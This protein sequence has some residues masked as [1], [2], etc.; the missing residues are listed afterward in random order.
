MA[1]APA[2]VQVQVE[3]PIGDVRI[4]P[5]SRDFQAAGGGSSLELTAPESGAVWI[6]TTGREPL[7][8]LVDPP[9]HDVPQAGDNVTIF[10]PGDH[11]V[12]LLE[13]TDGH[14]VYIAP[15]A[16]VYGGLIGSAA[17]V[18]IIGR[19]CLDAGRLE[20]PHKAIELVQ[21]RNVFIEG[22]SVRN[23]PC[24]TTA[25]MWCENVTYRNV[26]LF[27]DGRNGD[28]IDVVASRD[29][30]IEDC[31]F[32]CTD[33]CISL[34]SHVDP[35]FVSQSEDVENRGDIEDIRVSGCVMVGW[36]AS[37]GFTIGFES[38]GDYTRNIRVSDCDVIHAWG[39]NHAGGHS[40]FSV[41]CDGP[42]TISDV[43][44]ENIRAEE[45]VLKNFDI[46]ITDGHE[47]TMG[48]PGHIR[49]VTIRNC[50]WAADKPI[51]LRGHD[52]AHRVKG[53]RFE[54]CTVAGRPL[55]GPDAADVQIK[56]YVDDV[57]FSAE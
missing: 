38:R 4:G 13:L 21:A 3:G 10:G 27:S 37:D 11:D 17:D 14:T 50:H 47:Y 42:T 16:V 46:F 34:K 22:V 6:E 35:R 45:T 48:D 55:T 31:F 53:V 23:G 30:A 28:G 18:R 36:D 41:I 32:R 19:G 15:G 25:P 9:Q 39:G 57:T 2:E 8:L 5:A 40:A 49:D 24:W 33:D 29:V 56:E 1:D 54:G 7:A 20:R 43:I 26:K 51:L 12:G 44:F 52:D